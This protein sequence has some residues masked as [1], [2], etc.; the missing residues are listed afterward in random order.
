M[1]VKS[2]DQIEW[3]LLRWGCNVFDDLVIVVLVVSGWEM[4]G[5]R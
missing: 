4:R 1:M 5:T 3:V 2:S